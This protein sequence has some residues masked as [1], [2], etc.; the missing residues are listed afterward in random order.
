MTIFLA[1]KRIVHSNM[2]DNGLICLYINIT[3]ISS[4]NFTEPMQ[5]ICMYMK[6]ENNQSCG[7]I[8]KGRKVHYWNSEIIRQNE[9]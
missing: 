6:D 3:A 2:L 7:H 8:L 4:L 1:E 5:G 9:W